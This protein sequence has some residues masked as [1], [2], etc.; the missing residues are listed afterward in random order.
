MPS[1]AVAVGVVDMVL[2]ADRIAVRLAELARDR[3]E[4][5]LDAASEAAAMQAEI[6]GILQGTGRP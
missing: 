4:G 6:C 2:P 1:S 5:T 3:L